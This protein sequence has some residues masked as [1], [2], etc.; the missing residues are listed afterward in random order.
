VSAYVHKY[1]DFIARNFGTPE[2]FAQRYSVALR[3]TP[4]RVRGH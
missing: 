1:R 3:I 2:T 4:D